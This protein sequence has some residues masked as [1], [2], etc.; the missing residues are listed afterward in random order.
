MIPAF[1][2]NYENRLRRRGSIAAHVNRFL[3]KTFF[4]REQKK[5]E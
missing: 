1:R 5:L 3:S 2:Y 4:I